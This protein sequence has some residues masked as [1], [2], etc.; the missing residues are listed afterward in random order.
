MCECRPALL[1]GS[2]LL[3]LVLDLQLEHVDKL[4]THWN[5]FFFFLPVSTQS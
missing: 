1:L 3:T 5:S 4:T 2:C